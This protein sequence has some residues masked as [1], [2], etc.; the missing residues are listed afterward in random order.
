MPSDRKESSGAAR[1][2]AVLIVDDQPDVAETAADMLVCLDYDASVANSAT[3][4]L[5]R[6]SAGVRFDALFLDIGMRSGMSG[7]DLALIV[8][9]R[10]PGVAVL[11]TTG[12]GDALAEA[13]GQGFQVLAKPYFVSSLRDAMSRLLAARGTR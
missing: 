9:D 7:L 10:F 12:H 11:L 3:A 5:D 8:R 6:L 13:Q 4:A 1:R 2:P